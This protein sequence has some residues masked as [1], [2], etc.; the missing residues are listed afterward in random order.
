LYES[1]KVELRKRSSVIGGFIDVEAQHN[2]AAN[3]APIDFDVDEKLNDRWLN[4]LEDIALSLQH[5]DI[6]KFM[7][8][9][10]SNWRSSWVF[11]N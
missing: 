5:T 8:L 7:R 2:M 9:N 4:G 3:G 1:D 11:V 6:I 10:G